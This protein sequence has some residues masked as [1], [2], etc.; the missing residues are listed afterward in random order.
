MDLHIIPG[1]S[2]ED[3]AKAHV[4]D[5][6]CQDE[7]GCR[8]I[9]YW[10]DQ[11]RGKAFCLIEAPDLEA[12]T[13]LHRKAHG[14]VPNRVTP[15]DPAMVESF[16]GRLTDPDFTES[17]VEGTL[18][19]FEDSALRFLVRLVL[20]D[21][22]LL[23]ALHPS[24]DLRELQEYAHYILSELA[25][26]F[27][28]RRIT[29]I[30]DDFNYAFNSSGDALAFIMELELMLRR[31]DPLLEPGFAV[32]SGEPLTD[33]PGFFEEATDLLQALNYFSRKKKKVI[34][35]EVFNEGG[36]SKAHLQGKYPSKLLVLDSYAETFLIQLDKMV[37]KFYMNPNLDVGMLASHLAFSHSKLYRECKK[38]TGISPNRF[39]REYRLE[40]ALRLM[41]R[42]QDSISEIGFHCGFNT[43]SYFTR[44]FCDYFGVNP[45]EYKNELVTLHE[46][47][48]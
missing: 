32:I 18:N 5:L 34:G 33:K 28:A 31:K 22:N 44:C 37:G 23:R 27:N 46:M 11:S 40:Q 35:S 29:Y 19:V 48:Q 20:P 42:N 3:V 17:R 1:A 16:L 25:R 30:K 41:R 15:V 10:F 26:K 9:T 47:L 2:A 45:A 12:V 4:K 36:T 6:Y 13:E 43:P 39:I 8:A 21:F 14:L 7:F 38:V 24:K